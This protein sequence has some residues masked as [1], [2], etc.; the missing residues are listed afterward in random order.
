MNGNEKKNNFDITDPE[1]L[2]FKNHLI[3]N[4]DL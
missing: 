4:R 1:I 2:I 3:Q